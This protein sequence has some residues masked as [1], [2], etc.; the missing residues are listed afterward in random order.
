MS[1]LSLRSIRLE[2]RYTALSRKLW[3]S[4]VVSAKATENP[5]TKTLLLPKTSFPLRA[6]AAKRE[7]LF[8][9]RCTKDLYP[10]QVEKIICLVSVEVFLGNSYFFFF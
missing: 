10:W 2:P 4:A 5:Y 8:K 9:D 3:S 6:E 1:I 7:H